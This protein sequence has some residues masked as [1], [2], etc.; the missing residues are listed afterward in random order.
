M[1]KKYTAW[2]HVSIKTGDNSIANLHVNIV[3]VKE[4]TPAYVGGKYD[5]VEFL[6]RN[7]NSFQ[8]MEDK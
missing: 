8:V 3:E 2:E 7:G 4:S 6:Q 1:K 5:V